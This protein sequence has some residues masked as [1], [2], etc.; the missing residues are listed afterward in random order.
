MS[1]IR[2]TLL[3]LSCSYNLGRSSPNCFLCEH[4]SLP[5]IDICLGSSF[6][7]ST[8]YL[9]PAYVSYPSSCQWS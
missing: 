5:Q 9:C 3:L 4:S 7:R 1:E 6:P 2:I 8:A